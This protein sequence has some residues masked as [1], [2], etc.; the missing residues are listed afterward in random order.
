[1]YTND[2]G[3]I[4]RVSFWFQFVARISR[5][6]RFACV[7]WFHFGDT[8]RNPYPLQFH[9]GKS[10]STMLSIVTSNSYFDGRTRFI[11][12]SDSLNLNFRS[13]YQFPSSMNPR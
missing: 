12:G 5:A 10:N 9:F 8:L 6:I 13:L 4:A 11:L 1:M 7:L 3:K 2:S